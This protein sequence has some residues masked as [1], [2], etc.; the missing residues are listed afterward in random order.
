LSTERRASSRVDGFCSFEGR[1]YVQPRRAIRGGRSADRLAGS[2]HVLGVPWLPW[3]SKW[4][5]TASGRWW[6]RRRRADQAPNTRPERAERHYRQ[7]EPECGQR[8]EEP[9]IA[10]EHWRPRV[11]VGSAGLS[12]FQFLKMRSGSAASLRRSLPEVLRRPQPSGRRGDSRAT[13]GGD[14]W[15]CGPPLAAVPHPRKL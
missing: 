4:S 10:W 7:L 5:A 2:R 6:R 13:I 3:R 15:V 12:V 11:Y 9:G 8:A 14:H 1:C